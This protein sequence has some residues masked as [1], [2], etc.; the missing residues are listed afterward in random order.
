MEFFG[1]YLTEFQQQHGGMDCGRTVGV[2]DISDLLWR[3]LLTGNLKINTNVAYFYDDEGNDT[4][5]AA[6]LHS[7]DRVVLDAAALQLKRIMDANHSEMLAL[8]LG[9][10]LAKRC[11]VVHFTLESDSL[12]AVNCFSIDEEPNLS[13]W[14]SLVYHFHREVQGLQFPGFFT[15]IGC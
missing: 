14:G 10:E 3:T 13:S 1:S 4:N 12:N 9:I 15:I 6:V 11:G 7:S 8:L 2:A 5:A